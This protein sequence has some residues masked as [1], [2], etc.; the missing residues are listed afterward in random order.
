MNSTDLSKLLSGT[1]VVL[2]ANVVGSSAKLFERIILGRVLSPTTY[3]DV[4]VGLALLSFCTVIALAGFTESIPRFIPRFER[5]T[6]QRGVWFAGIV[7][8]GAITGSALVAIYMLEPF[9]VGRLFESESA[10]SMLWLFSLSIPF[11]VAARITAAAIRGHGNTV[12]YEIVEDLAYPAIRILVLVALLLAGF[13]V[14]AAGYAYLLAAAFASVLAHLFL[15]RIA[16]LLG[17]IEVQTR[18]LLVFSLP[19]VVAT[20]SIFLLHIVDTM[21]LGYFR[22]STDVGIYNAAYPLAMSIATVLQSF[23]ILFLPMVSELD[24]AREH[25][26]IR[27]LYRITTK[28]MYVATFPVFLLFVAF[29]EDVLAAIFGSEYAVGGTVL[30]VLSVGFF[31]RVIAGLNNETLM[32]LGHTRHIMYANIT[33]FIGN[34]A[35]NVVLIPTYGILGAAVASALSFIYINIFLCAVLWVGFDVTPVSKPLIRAGI[36]TLLLVPVAILFSESVTLSFG[37]LVGTSV[38]AIVVTV[39]AV[40][41]SGGL[42]AADEIFLNYVEDAAGITVPYVR[43]FL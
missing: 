34:I 28:W 22:P 41:T 23:G 19:L 13:G 27:S 15:N 4:S 42:E 18:E 40:V 1:T 38:L 37:G 29:P 2:V 10:G 35:L 36:A 17:A 7:V 43:R 12:Y 31:V 6:Q 39:L 25:E 26:R 30:I 9:L 33:A 8:T 16:P 5:R 21:M 32:A 20:T 24:A 11:I 3:G 14:L